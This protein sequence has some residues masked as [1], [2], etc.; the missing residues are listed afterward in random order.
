VSTQGNL[1]SS[2]KNRVVVSC[3]PVPGGPMDTTAIVAAMGLAA[4][5]GGAAGLRIEGIAS[6]SRMRTV[7]ALPI[8]G[9]VKRDISGSPV[10]IT[11]TLED[12]DA[13]V[14]AG[15][16]IIAYDATQRKRPVPTAEIVA[17][18][19]DKGALAMA[20][21]ARIEDGHQALA[22]GADILGTTLSGY[23]YGELPE[24]A[25]PD[26]NLVRELAGLGAFVIAEG[27]F[28][29][30]DEAAEAIRHG[31]DSIVVGS[32]ITRIEHVTAWFSDAIREAADAP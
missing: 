29:T 23:A 4:E 2:L 12:V 3:Q 15:A 9:I 8:I 1:L 19:R 22:E 16:G 27:R 20:D 13:L 30:P 18:I 6:V 21:C 31:A 7:T 17:R 28:R 24:H 10:R 5:Y 26:L 32:A 25:P 11:P 14:T